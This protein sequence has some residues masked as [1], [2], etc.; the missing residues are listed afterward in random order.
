[1]IRGQGE[2]EIIIL[3]YQLKFIYTRQYWSEILSNSRISL[4]AEHVSLFVYPGQE[5]ARIPGTGFVSDGH[6]V[7]GKRR[8]AIQTVERVR[9]VNH[10]TCRG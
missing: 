4:H 5:A 9:L 7:E 10:H 1:M 8:L 3:L 2:L 6:G